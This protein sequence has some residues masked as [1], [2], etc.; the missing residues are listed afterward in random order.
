MPS[1][2][3]NASFQNFKFT[4]L[5]CCFIEIF[6]IIFVIKSEVEIVQKGYMVTIAAVEAYKFLLLM[7]Q[8]E[9]CLNA[10]S[11]DEN[12]WFKTLLLDKISE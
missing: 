3:R 10:T 1:Q 12:S 5:I 8:V 2:E 4:V 11:L 9:D 7:R 6:K